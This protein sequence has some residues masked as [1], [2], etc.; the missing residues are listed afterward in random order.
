M[1]D[2]RPADI[3]KF[4]EKVQK[5]RGVGACWLWTGRPKPDGSGQQTLMIGGKQKNQRAPCL[6]YIPH[7]GPI[8]PGLE[9][10]QK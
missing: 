7:F 1:D 2:F 10:H 6:S 5:G 4:W 9:I 8:P 3:E